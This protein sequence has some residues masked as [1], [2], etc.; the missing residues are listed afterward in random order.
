[1]CNALSVVSVGPPLADPVRG[2][3][4]ISHL[5]WYVNGARWAL[6]SI[7]EIRGYTLDAVAVPPARPTRHAPAHRYLVDS[8]RAR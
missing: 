2:T 7:A 4:W 5:V 8:L 3:D 6:E 1:L